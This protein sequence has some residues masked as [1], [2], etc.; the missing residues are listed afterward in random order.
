VRVQRIPSLKDIAP[1]RVV[2]QE[3]LPLPAGVE[4]RPLQMHGD[5]R[6]AF[7]ELHR[8]EWCIGA[9][10][11]QWNMVRSHANVLRGV[12]AHRYHV[13]Y[14]T[15]AFGE[16]VLG[17]HDLRAA[18]PTR[19]LTAML[20]LSA[21]NLHLVVV[22]TGVAHGFFFPGPGLP[23]LRGDDRVR[24]QRRVRLPLGRTGAGV[25][26]AVHSTPVVGTRSRSGLL[27]RSSRRT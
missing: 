20:R 2:V 18:S 5:E 19:G 12:H 27:C 23:H 9:R 22:P 13:D 14:L 6:G 4:L 24:R 8:D 7:T 17:L 25:R 3:R 16:M 11:V 15:M 1:A 21:D 26:M 10:P